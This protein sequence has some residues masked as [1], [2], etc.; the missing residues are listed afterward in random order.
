MPRVARSG[1]IP[2]IP[3]CVTKSSECYLPERSSNRFM[4]LLVSGDAVLRIVVSNV[5][6]VW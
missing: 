1:R 6:V 5:N 3:E 2:C 4:V